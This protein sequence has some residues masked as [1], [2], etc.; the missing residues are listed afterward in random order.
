MIRLLPICA[1]FRVGK[2]RSSASGRAFTL[3][4][5]LVVIAI[6]A[7]LAA[8]LLPVLGAARDRG[9]QA[10]CVNNLRQ[11]GLIAAQYQNDYDGYLPA[12][13]D[14]SGQPTPNDNTSGGPA[15]MQ[16]QFY[17]SGISSGFNGKVSTR[18]RSFYCPSDTRKNRMLALTTST[19]EDMRDI[20]Y[21]ANDS[22]WSKTAGSDLRAIRPENISTK[23]GAG[24]G[25]VIMFGEMDNG[26]PGTAYGQTNGYLLLNDTNTSFAA[27]TVS[28]L[29]TY[30]QWYLMFRHNRA[31]GMNLLYFDNHVAF[32]ADYTSA[33]G[34]YFGS[35][36]GSWYN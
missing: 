2:R 17:N 36:L 4:E 31:R 23:D 9:K 22:C 1:S 8:I 7:M 19:T 5:L 15:G 25:N 32:A 13:K 11:I 24:S 16:L 18:V 29:G 28:S 35:L 34:V 30:V 14:A 26:S 12:A 20:S 6:V 33:P 10:V 21:A 3:I 27:A